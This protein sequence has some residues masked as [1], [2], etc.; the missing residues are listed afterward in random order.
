MT[1]QL[2]SGSEE[3]QSDDSQEA[4]HREPERGDSPNPN[5]QKITF[6]ELLKRAKE[7]GVEIGRTLADEEE[8]T[9]PLIDLIS[10]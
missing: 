3:S 8:A 5:S 2:S 4:G 9:L 1:E 7:M 6:G 10:K